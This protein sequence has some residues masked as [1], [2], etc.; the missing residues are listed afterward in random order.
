[1]FV[2]CWFAVLK[3]GAVAVA[4]MPLLRARELEYVC[5]KAQVKYALCDTRLG[6]EMKKTLPGAEK[7]K[8]SI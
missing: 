5:N 2:A 4:T 8:K 7:L 3:V 6:E 1:M